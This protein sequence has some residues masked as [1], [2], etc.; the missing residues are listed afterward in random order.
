MSHFRHWYLYVHSLTASQRALGSGVD[1]PFFGS[2]GLRK[3]FIA[4]SLLKA[5]LVA[6]GTP[7]A[8]I[9]YMVLVRLN[10]I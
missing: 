4:Q 9:M 2:Q 3:A 1:R 6:G 7:R 8:G 5:R 10:W